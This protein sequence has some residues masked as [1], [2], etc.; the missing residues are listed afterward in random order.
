[1]AVLG[2]D[3]VPKIPCEAKDNGSS[4]VSNSESV[5]CLN[6]ESVGKTRLEIIPMFV[7]ELLLKATP[8]CSIKPPMKLIPYRM[9]RIIP[10]VTVVVILLKSMA[11]QTR[12]IGILTK[13]AAA[14]RIWAPLT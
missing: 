11:T 2:G 10:P 13:K 1:M 12:M 4:A 6:N 14:F 5:V 8:S 3:V 7:S 9:I